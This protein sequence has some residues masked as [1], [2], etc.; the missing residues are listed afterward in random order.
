MAL[1]IKRIV[2]WVIFGIVALLVAALLFVDVGPR[3]LPYQALVVR[4]GSMTPTIPT[5]SIVLYH[6]VD[7]SDLKVGNIIVF[8][9]PG[10]TTMVTHRIYAIDS[11]STG[12][13][14]ETKGDANKY[15]DDWRIPDKGSGWETFWHMP[16]VG[17]FLEDIQSGWTRILM[18]V[19][20]ALV[21]GGLALAD[22]VRTRRPRQTVPPVPSS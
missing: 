9:E 11:T 4:S 12:K 17:Y 7:A 20:P 3:F 15:P 6:K 16:V 1:R 21:L 8:T 10:T 13:Y 18:I 14:I 5:G 22:F 19:V 2:E